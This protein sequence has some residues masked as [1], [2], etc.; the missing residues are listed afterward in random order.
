VNDFRAGPSARGWRCPTP[1][2]AARAFHAA[3]PDYRPTPLVALP[4]LAAELGV[5]RVLVKD[6]SARLGLPAFKILGASW[7]VARVAA[8]RAGRATVPD[9]LE[10][11]AGQRLTLVTATDGNHGR[12]VAR[13][14]ALLRLDAH[15]V[16]PR[17]MSAGAE[18]AIRAALRNAG[19]APEDIDAVVAHGTGTRLNDNAEAAALVRVLGDRV[20]TVPLTAPKAAI[21]HTLGAAGAFGAVIGAQMLRSGVVPPTINYETPDPDC[22]VHVVA[23]EPLA[24]AP[25][26]VLTNAFAFGGQNA[27][28]VLRAA[29]AA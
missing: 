9:D 29:D 20:A 19:A 15:V 12:A 18:R 14:A 26:T 5:A 10:A 24:S 23:G 17:T 27:V 7:A 11:I 25:R 4:A 1:S 2:G 22:P 8:R 21:G 6:E 13:M 16:V 28:V 3:L